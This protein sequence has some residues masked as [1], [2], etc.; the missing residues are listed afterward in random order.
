VAAAVRAELLQLKP[1]WI[2]TPVLPG[3]VVPVLAFL[4]SQRD[5]R[6]DIGGSH[7]A[8]PFSSFR[9]VQGSIAQGSIDQNRD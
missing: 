9:I 3:D 5:L 6:P 1:V 4:A 7:D 2:V 8:A